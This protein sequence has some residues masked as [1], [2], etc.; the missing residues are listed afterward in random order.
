MAIAV[1]VQP[2]PFTEMGNPDG[3]VQAR[4]IFLLALKNAG[5]QVPWLQRLIFAFRN[6]T[7]LQTLVAAADEQAIVDLMRN[8]LNVGVIDDSDCAVQSHA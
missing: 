8:H 4:L 2:V 7:F 6:E 3:T 5:D 1:P